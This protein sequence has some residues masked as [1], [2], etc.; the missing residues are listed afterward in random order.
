MDFND[1][2]TIKLR[3]YLILSGFILELFIFWIIL[4]SGSLKTLLG[5]LL[6]Y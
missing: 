5:R 4:I 2:I 3:E 6:I 1:D